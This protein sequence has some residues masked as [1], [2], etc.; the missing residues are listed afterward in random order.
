VEIR[1]PYIERMVL[2]AEK[3]IRGRIEHS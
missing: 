1:L 3:I 2:E